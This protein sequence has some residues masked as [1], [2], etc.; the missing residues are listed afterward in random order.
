VFLVIGSVL[1]IIWPADMEWK[2]DEQWMVTRAIAAV[3][4]GAL[5]WLGM[6]SGVQ[7]LNPGFSIWPFALMA[8]FTEDPVAMVQW[9]QWSNVIALWAFFW[10]FVRAVPAEARSVWLWGLALFAVSPFAIIFSR[11]L[12]AQNVLP[13]FCAAVL[14]G[15]FYRR[16]RLG[17][18]AWGLSGAL[19]GQIHMSGF[20]LAFALASVT[21][22]R[23]RRRGE[24][25]STR[26]AYWIAGGLIGGVSLLPWLSAIMAGSAGH[27]AYRFREILTLNFYAQWFL[28]AWGIALAGTRYAG[29]QFLREPLIWG[30]PTY[31]MLLAHIYLAGVGL[32]IT[33]RWL[34]SGL[35]PRFDTQIGFYILVTFGVVGALLTLFGIRVRPHYL[36]VVVPF[37]HI[38]AAGVTW[39]RRRLLASV[40]AAQMVVSAT[41][42]AFVHRQGGI[43]W[44]DYGWS[45]R[46][47]QAGGTFKVDR[48]AGPD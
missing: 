19:M 13:I 35:R 24:L 28:A 37:V 8:R 36:V 32:W 12:W 20:F 30:R 6:N 45:Y 15:H 42:L 29:V 33:L 17:A 38:W 26:W 31:L 4:D 48:P 23:D 7:I 18:F 2:F 11:K 41:F 16:T 27:S 40:A 47:Q 10:L 34:A 21:V 39:P 1:R 9:I 5:P 14:W 44:A 46:A 43:P 25:R 22:L 3:H